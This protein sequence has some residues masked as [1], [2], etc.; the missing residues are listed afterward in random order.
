MAAIVAVGMVPALGMGAATFFAKHKF[1]DS[2]REA[3]KA[4][5][6]LGFCFISE[7]AIPFAAK[8]QCVF[9]RLVY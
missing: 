2:E 4:S 9:Y 7:G 8:D 6:V 5:F 3:G 1:D